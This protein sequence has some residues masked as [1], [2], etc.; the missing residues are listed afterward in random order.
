MGE[1]YP[2]IQYRSDDRFRMPWSSLCEIKLPPITIS[3][4]RWPCPLLNLST[5]VV[6][7]EF[8]MFSENPPTRFCPGICKGNRAIA[9]PRSKRGRRAPVPVIILPELQFAD[10][11]SPLFRSY[12][13]HAPLSNAVPT[14]RSH[15]PARRRETNF[16]QNKTQKNRIR[17]SAIPTVSLLLNILIDMHASHYSQRFNGWIFNHRTPRRASPRPPRTLSYIVRL[18]PAISSRLLSFC[19]GMSDPRRRKAWELVFLFFLLSLFRLPLS[20]DEI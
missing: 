2:S 4:K 1:Q 3:E 9:F 7:L 13:S 5:A 12:S 14:P 18:R 19:S 20:T 10:N 11:M 6:H 15:V 8:Q 16:A 17:P